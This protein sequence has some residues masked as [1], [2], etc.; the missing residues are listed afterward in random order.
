V[1]QERAQTPQPL[2]YE[3]NIMSNR[4]SKSFLDIRIN[5]TE[6][7]N[8]PRFCREQA[9]EQVEQPV[10]SFGLII[11]SLATGITSIILVESY[12]FIFLKIPLILRRNYRVSVE[13]TIMIETD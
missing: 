4:P 1:G 8:S 10:Q 9:R 2:Q 6:G 12:F 13:L 7:L 5:A 3:E 11:I